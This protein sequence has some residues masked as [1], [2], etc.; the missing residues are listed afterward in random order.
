[1]VGACGVGKTTLKMKFMSSKH[2]TEGENLDRANFI[3]LRESIRYENTLLKPP[4][5]NHAVLLH[6]IQWIIK[7][8]VL[9]GYL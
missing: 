2:E 8:L 3:L 5:Y 7:R 6:L 4:T 1:M 9:R